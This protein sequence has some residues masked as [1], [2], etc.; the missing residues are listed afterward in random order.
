M[1]DRR[2]LPR[3][4]FDE[5]CPS[6]LVPFRF[7]DNKWSAL[8]LRCLED[9]PRRFSELRVPLHRVTPKVLT[10]SLRGLER[11]GLISRTVRSGPAPHVEYALTP[12]GRGM[13]E[14]LAT[15]CA[16]AAENWDQIL[17]ARERHP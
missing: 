8:V 4:M 5:V 15:A 14:P 2:P 1:S 9:G 7:G 17:D 16:W 3:D 6:G 10:Q 13:L 12:L 11:R